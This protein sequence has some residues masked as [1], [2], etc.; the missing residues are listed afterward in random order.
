MFFSKF[1]PFLFVSLWERSKKKKFFFVLNR[2]FLCR[3][4]NLNENKE[5]CLRLGRGEVFS[6]KSRKNERKS[7]AYDLNNTSG[8][9]VL[10]IVEQVLKVF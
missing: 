9:G 10:C 1:S 2:L 5:Q 8:N 6:V 7:F 4:D 3:I